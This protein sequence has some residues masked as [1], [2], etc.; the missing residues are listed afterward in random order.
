ML[1]F[2]RTQTQA[3]PP[4]PPLSPKPSRPYREIRCPDMLSLIGFNDDA[5]MLSPFVSAFDAG[6]VK[7]V[8]GLPMAV[9]GSATNMTAGLRLANDLLARMPKGLRRRIW[10]LSDGGGN[11]PEDL[12]GGI[13]RQVTRAREQYTNIN[14][15]GF[16]DPGQFNKELLGCIAAATHNGKYFEATTVHA[17]GTT[18]RR[19]AGR[20]R[21]AA[22]RGEAT[23]FVIDCSGSMAVYQMGG[24]QRIE[25]VRDAMIDLL[26]YKQA[27]WS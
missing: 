3:Q 15:I 26:R 19:A 8:Q 17:L 24:R 23:V 6:F 18:F 9:T 14:T 1:F 11:H 22:H 4:Q 13:T 12:A 10:L 2:N 16:G 21:N 5:K 25:V 7:A 27:V 20:D